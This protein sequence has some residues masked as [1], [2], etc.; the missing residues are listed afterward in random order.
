MTQLTHWSE[1]DRCFLT[2]CG[3]LELTL[4]CKSLG[5][6]CHTYH[7]FFLVY[8]WC[9]EGFFF[10]P[11]LK[12][13]FVFLL[14]SGNRP[15]RVG[16][17]FFH[18]TVWEI[19]ERA[20][21]SQMKMLYL[22]L[23]VIHSLLYGSEVPLGMS[24]I[25]IMFLSAGCGIWIS[26]LAVRYVRSHVARQLPGDSTAAN[27]EELELSQQG[28][29][30]FTPGLRSPWAALLLPRLILSVAQ[31]GESRRTLFS[32]PKEVTFKGVTCP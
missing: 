15:E 31:R 2:T 26:D 29:L 19:I 20:C 18:I 8:S 17:D 12:A 3:I 7:N 32:S 28:Q 22:C 10:S 27:T 24:Q 16:I 6:N 30:S 13:L 5:W 21:M 4:H 23:I 11:H 25:H 9:I 14:I 1:W